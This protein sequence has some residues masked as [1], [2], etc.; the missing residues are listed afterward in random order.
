[1]AITTNENDLWNSGVVMSGGVPADDPPVSNCDAWCRWSNADGQTQLLTGTGTDDSDLAAGTTIGIDAPDHQG[2]PVG[3]LVGQWDY[4]TGAL[5]DIGVAKNV[6]GVGDLTLFYWDLNS[7]DNQEEI[8]VRLA[9]KS[10]QCTVGGDPNKPTSAQGSARGLKPIPVAFSPSP[11]N[12]TNTSGTATFPAAILPTAEI[13]F[14]PD[15]SPVIAPTGVV[16]TFAFVNGVPT[17]VFDFTVSGS[18][19]LKVKLRNLDVI[20]GVTPGGTCQNGTTIARLEI[21]NDV[22][23]YFVGEASIILKNCHK[24]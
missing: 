19:E 11:L 4:P 12:V 6:A 7:L 9:E 10:I 18:G 13:T 8:N 3:R 15:G 20:R 1:L 24:L 22:T 23:G 16:D 5:F 14:G 2:R 21:G 17:Q